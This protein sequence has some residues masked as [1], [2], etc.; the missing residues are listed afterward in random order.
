[1]EV[2]TRQIP[3]EGL[4]LTEE[5]NPK[6]LDLGTEMIKFLSPLKARADISKS[7][8]AVGVSL[9]L[10]A[11]VSF[12]CSRCLNEAR[13]SLD[14][15]VEL[16]FAI[17]K[18]DPLILLDPV[19]REEIILDY[20]IKPLCKDDCKGLCLKCGGNLNEGG[21]HCGST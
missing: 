15:Q 6:T 12:D 5:F 13:V 2:D 19:I 1:M 8:N 18:L 7:Y 10:N 16:N 9:S 17:D 14:K 21:C 3:E 11:L 4:I 20:P